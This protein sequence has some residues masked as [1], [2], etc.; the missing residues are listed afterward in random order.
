MILDW[1]IEA[2]SLSDELLTKVLARSHATSSEATTATTTPRAES[3]IPMIPRCI[4]LKVRL[5]TMRPAVP[6]TAATPRRVT[7]ATTEREDWA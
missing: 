2:F 1:S 6:Q 7:S 3:T 5:P 4:R